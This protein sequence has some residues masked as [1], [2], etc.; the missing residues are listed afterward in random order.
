MHQPPT[1]L[2]VSRLCQVRAVSRRGDDEWRDR[3]PRP[4]VDADQP[5][6]DNVQRGVAPGRGTYGPRRITH[7]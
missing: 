3:S 2:T 5:V 7:R 1:E 4:R 6:Q